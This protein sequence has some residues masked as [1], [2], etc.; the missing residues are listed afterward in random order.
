MVGRVSAIVH[1]FVVVMIGF[2]AIGGALALA[3][4]IAFGLDFYR[5]HAQRED[6]PLPGALGSSPWPELDEA[7]A[8]QERRLVLVDRPDYPVFDTDWEKP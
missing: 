3:A 5:H 2:A 8:E 1:G 6:K 7:E 4:A